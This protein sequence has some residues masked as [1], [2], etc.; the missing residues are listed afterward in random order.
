MKTSPKDKHPETKPTKERHQI[1]KDNL[2]TTTTDVLR[3]PRPTTTT[4]MCQGEGRKGGLGTR[5]KAQTTSKDNKATQPTI[6]QW[7]FRS[8]DIR[9]KGQGDV[10]IDHETVHP[11]NQSLPVAEAKTTAGARPE[12]K[13]KIWKSE[14]LTSKE[15]L[16]VWNAAENDSTLKGEQK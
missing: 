3:Q 11:Q 6:K 15:H 5:P 14:V 13:E 1:T 16:T 7:I 2:Q 12:P 4:K 9:Y 10:T 8:R